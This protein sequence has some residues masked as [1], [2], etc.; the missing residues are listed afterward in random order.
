[1]REIM[2]F[3]SKLFNWYNDDLI[4]FKNT[5]FLKFFCHK[6]ENICVIKCKNKKCNKKSKM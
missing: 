4:L 1:M 2:S 5:F 3:M 6:C